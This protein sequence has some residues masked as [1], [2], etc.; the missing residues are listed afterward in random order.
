[1]KKIK[2]LI[3]CLLYFKFILFIFIYSFI[4]SIDAFSLGQK[5]SPYPQGAGAGRSNASVSGLVMDGTACRV[6]PGIAPATLPQLLGALKECELP[7]VKTFSAIGPE[8][9]T[10][11]YMQLLVS[12]K[13]AGRP[14]EKRLWSFIE[15]HQTHVQENMEGVEFP[16]DPGFKGGLIESNTPCAKECLSP[17]LN[18]IYESFLAKKVIEFERTHAGR[19]IAPIFTKIM[20]K[21]SEHYGADE[22]ERYKDG[23]SKSPLN[24]LY[25]VAQKS[26]KT[27]DQIKSHLLAKDDIPL[28][29]DYY[30]GSY[31][32][33]RPLLATTTLLPFGVSLDAS[34]KELQ[35]HCYKGEI[36]RARGSKIPVDPATVRETR[37]VGIAKGVE[38]PGLVL[39]PAHKPWKHS[40][41]SLSLTDGSSSYMT[42][43]KLRQIPIACGVSGTT[44][45]ALWSLFSLNIDVTPKE[46]RAYLLA[47]WA[48]LCADGGHSLQEVLSATQIVMKYISEKGLAAH[49]NRTT[50]NSLREVTRSLS[51]DGTDDPRKFGYYHDSFFRDLEAESPDFVTI[52]AAAQREFLDYFERSACNAAHDL[53]H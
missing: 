12:R 37:Q 35:D 17:A 43:A 44:N 13:F 10:R 45:I 42:Q 28:L 38:V 25:P 41:E 21:L 30:I 33:H 4:Y 1:M 11:F 48:N 52:R 40:G 34:L 26:L 29:F 6:N 2:C 7:A 5:Q 15:N 27:S 22:E 8:C 31:G 51:V 53:V 14:F 9:S 32:M 18:A 36:E 16:A 19:N 24:S 47:N 49:L 46:L 39:D 20:N 23:W 3:R 50:L